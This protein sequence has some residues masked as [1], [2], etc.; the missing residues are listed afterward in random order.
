MLNEAIELY[1]SMRKDDFITSTHS[2]NRLLRTLVDLLQARFHSL[3]TVIVGSK[4]IQAAVMLK[5]LDKGFE[6]MKSME[7]DGMGPSVFAYNLLLS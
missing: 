7:K 3:L 2:V 4:A 6:F 1:S 5:D